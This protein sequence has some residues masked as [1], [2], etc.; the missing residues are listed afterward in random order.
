MD[1]MAFGLP[2]LCMYCHKG[3]STAKAL[4]KHENWHK[5]KYT[6]Y[7][8]MC[9]KGFMSASSLRGHMAVHTGVKEFKC[10]VCGKDYAYKHVLK[11]HMIRKHGGNP[12]I[13]TFIN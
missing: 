4:Q 9:G 12:H 7:C 13:E 11:D 6:S 8:K 10:S 3:F 1:R 2:N 5:G